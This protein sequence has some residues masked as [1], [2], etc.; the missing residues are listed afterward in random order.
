M[1]HTKRAAVGAAAAL[2]AAAGATAVAAPSGGGPLGG[3]F[4]P[5]P[6]ERRAEQA[7]D[8]AKE[9][10]LPEQRVRQAIERVAKRRRAEHRAE[11]AKELAKRLDVSE[12][13]ALRA[14]AK[15]REA[16]R[17]ELDSNRGGQGLRPRG[18][19]DAFV[20]AVA[21]EL[22]KSADEVRR[23]LRDIRKERLNRKLAEAVEQGRLTQRQ[24]D[25]IKREA[26]QGPPRLRFRGRH[27][28]G[29]PG[30]PHPGAGRRNGDFVLPAP[31]PAGDE[32]GAEELPA[33]PP[34]VPG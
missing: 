1:R 7:G 28:P 8:L 15:G 14:L 4:G 27:G 16:L 33:P 22:D 24:A 25:R 32:E 21:G 29:G 13:D 3:V 34:G 11:R 2:A 5:S 30:G 9:L 23:A 18:D 6:Q 20:K 31:P 19:H 17:K 12:E 26:E 10:E